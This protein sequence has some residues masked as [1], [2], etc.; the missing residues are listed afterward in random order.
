MPRKVAV[1]ASRFAPYS[2]TF[3][4]DQVRHHQRY[5]A[6]VF[7]RERVNADRFQFTPVHHLIPGR[8]FEAALYNVTT[9]SPSFSRVLRAGGFSLF[10]GHFGSGAC[11]ALPYAERLGLPLVATFH[12]YDVPILAS[13]DRFRPSNWGYWAMSRWLFR[14]ADLL[15]PVSDDL[16]AMLVRVG[17]PAERIRV[18]RLGIDVD[19]EPRHDRGD[20]R[21]VA[22]MIG[23]FTE[24]KGFADGIRAFAS[25]ARDVA[26]TTLRIIGDG[27]LRGEYEALIRSLG[28]ADQIELVDPLSHQEVLREMQRADIAIVPSVTGRRGDREGGPL[29]IREAGVTGLAIVATRHAAISE[30]IED[31]VT[32]LLVAE[33]DIVGLAAALRRLF[34]NSAERLAL[35]LKARAYMQQ[36]FRQADRMAALE[37]LYDEAVEI[38]RTRNQR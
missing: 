24:K 35:G 23:R 12:G 33:H 38:R 36:H 37:Q 28:M 32:G 2:Q 7:T 17:A 8:G 22:I 15:L 20:G 34:V 31:Q 10:H 30:V 27:P 3:V 1:F 13:A 25:A 6:Q 9:W 5:T 14:R 26:G 4:Y 16:A 18:H 29:V 21:I 11:Y 19:V